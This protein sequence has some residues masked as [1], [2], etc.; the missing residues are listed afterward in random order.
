MK[1]VA[2][3]V[4]PGHPDRL[5]DS[6][7]ESIVTYV[8]QK[9]P[10]AL[11]GLECAVHTNKVFV[12]GR[13]AAGKSEAVISEAK[14][15]EIV[16]KVYKDAG[17]GYEQYKVRYWHPYPEEI[18][19][20]LN[21]CIELLSDDERSIRKYSDDQNIV[22]GFAVNDAR[23]KNM[24]IEH[25]LANF[26]GTNLYDFTKYLLHKYGPDFKVL[27]E[28]TKDGSSIE[29]S[30][31]T[32]SLQHTRDIVFSHIYHFIVNVINKA[33]LPNLCPSFQSLRSIDP[34][35]IYVNGA[36]DFV[37]GG[38]EG[39]NGLSG[40][41]LVIDFYGPSVPIGGGAICGKDPH[42]VDV[43]G[44]FRSR[45]LALDLVNKYGYYSV[46]TK[47][48]WSPGEMFPYL[49]EAYEI[50]QFGFKSEIDSNL[51]PPCDWFS[52]ECINNDMKLPEIDKKKKLLEGYLFSLNNRK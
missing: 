41:K 32:V 13:I 22:I 51:L 1:L 8:V 48:A 52:I 44:A 40:K 37:Q 7:V 9:D 17:Y 15:K 12:D 38:T 6:I 39:D 24:P 19:I 26:I 43:C 18:D 46:F 47:L 36:G 20:I 34:K 30:R 21:V 50:D 49:I 5:A 14:I 23:T 42:K 33:T 28:L 45:Q 31:L 11:C 3:Y 29:W 35:L 25:Y 10:D 4:S 27:V 16:R 2:E